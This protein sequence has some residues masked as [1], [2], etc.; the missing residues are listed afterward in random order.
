MDN[1]SKNLVIIL[2][3]H[4]VGKMTVGQE[5]A[6]TT[7]L[8]L[9]HN[10]MSIELT[11]KLFHYQE[12]ERSV[13]NETI[14]ETVFELF[15]KGDFPGLIFTF[16]CAFDMQSEF[17]Y[18]Q[19]VIDLFRSNGANCYVVELCA[20]FEERLIRNKSENRLIH[21]ESK[22]NLEWSEAEMR[23]TSEKYRLNSYEGEELPFENF[24]KIDNTT[25]SPEETAK[26]IREHFKIECAEE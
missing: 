5:L 2:G 19:H 15:A 24:L 25:L 10:H 17:D 14:R 1:V 11:L 22:R 26:M 3:P 7:G 23:K 21:K 6:K 18:L 20:D 12:K 16:M 9:F 4:A 8:R 13:L